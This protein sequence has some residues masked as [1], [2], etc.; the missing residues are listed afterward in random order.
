MGKIEP[1][2]ISK[3]YYP[4]FA[5]L[6]GRRCL[7]VGGGLVAQRKAM[8]LLGYGARVTVVSP[9][10]T[11]RLAACARRGAIRHL[12]RRIRPADLLGAWLVCA[13]TDDQRV[14]ETVSRVANASRVFANVV[15][16]K[17]L[18]SFIAPAIVRRGA[19]TIAISTGGASPALAKQ[20]RRDLGR[21][22]GSDYAPML[23]LLA[24][25]R[26]AA[27]R[28][29][30]SP[31]DRKRYFNELVRGRVFGLVRGGKRQAARQKALELLERHA[32]A[33]GT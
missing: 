9:M 22:I 30:P 2:P 8:T 27:K 33:N 23:R 21:I 19:L 28:R 4:M 17:L 32:A 25:L 31:R 15:D 13:A 10:V 29:L 24:G 16:Q 18:C 11:K 26:G 14:N 6:A 20:L 3:A 7:V 12:A 5:D 1:V